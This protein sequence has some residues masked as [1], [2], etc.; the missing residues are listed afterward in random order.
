MARTLLA[1]QSCNIAVFQCIHYLFHLGS[2][3]TLHVHVWDV[4]IYVY[5]YC[6][7]VCFI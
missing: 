6:T 4:S 5:M 7:V 1:L 2:F 3:I